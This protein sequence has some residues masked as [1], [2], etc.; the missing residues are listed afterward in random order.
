MIRCPSCKN[1]Y[2]GPF[3]C[4]TCGA[5][6]LYDATLRTAE[7]RAEKAER[8][9]AAA[10]ASLKQTQ[11]AHMVANDRA[12]SW[13]DELAAAQKD[14]ERYRWLRDKKFLH[15]WHPNG[16]GWTIT[17]VIPGD[18]LDAAIDA[19]KEKSK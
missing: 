4:V 11:G 7:R 1:A 19:A 12:E 6:K 13:Q 5:Q 3:V 9:L 14:A 18:D 2:T 10:Q 15:V 17:E 8:E 16:F